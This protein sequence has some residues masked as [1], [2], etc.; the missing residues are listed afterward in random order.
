MGVIYKMECDRC[1]TKFDHQAGVGFFC[2]CRDCGE[3]QDESSPFNC[4]VCSRRF[5]P[6]SATF[7]ESV[8]ETILWD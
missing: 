8:A 7:S 6:E 3:Q 2:A 5:D 4:P 1:G